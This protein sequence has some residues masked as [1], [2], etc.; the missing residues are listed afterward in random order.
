MQTERPPTTDRPMPPRSNPTRGIVLLAAAVVL[1]LFLLRALEDSSASDGETATGPTE[2]TAADEGDTTDTT[3][4]EEDQTTT[5]TLPP[6]RPPAEVTVLV[7]NASG[8]TGAAGARTDQLAAEGYQTATPT[9]APEGQ[10]L[11]ATQ[12]LFVQGFQPE[13]RALA[14]SLGAPTDGVAGMPEPPPVDP[15]GAQVVVLLG[16]DIA[17]PG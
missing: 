15:A 10:L 12:V 11:D 17:T 3:G 9:N 16:T 14:E 13:A 7:A 6:P 8:V 1:G 5:T 4:G 2:T